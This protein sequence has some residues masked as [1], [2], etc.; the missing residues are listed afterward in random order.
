MVIL[1]FIAEV[2]QLS[3]GQVLT[4][5]WKLNNIVHDFLEEKGEMHGEK[6]FCV[7]I[8]VFNDFISDLLLLKAISMT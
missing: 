8:M 6:R 7:V 5:C 1:S 2:R 4:R 3:R